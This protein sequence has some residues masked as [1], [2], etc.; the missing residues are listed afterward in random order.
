MCC[1]RCGPRWERRR[2]VVGDLCSLAG[3]AGV[4]KTALVR[5]FC[6]E[7]GRPARVLWGA[8]D[9]LFT[10]R[11]LGPVPRR[12]RRG[13]GARRG[14]R[15]R[16]L[17]PHD[18]A[19]ALLRAGGARGR[20]SS[21][22]RTC[23]GPTRR[24]S[25]SCGCWPAA[26]AARRLLVV[27]TYRDDE[28]ERDASAADRARRARDAQRRRAPRRGAALARRRRRAGRA[29]A[30]STRRS[31]TGR[32]PATRSSS[33]RS[34][35]RATRDPARRSARRCSGAPRGSS[36]RPGTLLEA[37]AVSPQRVEVWLLEALAGERAERARGVPGVGHARRRGRAPS[38]SGT[39]SR[40]WRSRRR[41]S[42][43]GGS[44]CTGWRSP[45]SPTRPRGEPDVVR[46]AHHA[47]A[48]GDVEAVL[49]YAPEAGARAA[50]LRRASRGRRAVRP[51]AALRRRARPEERADLLRRYSDSCYLTDRCDDAIEAP[52]SCSTCHRAAGDRFKEGETLSLSRSCR[53]A[54][55]ASREAEPDGAAGDRAA[56]GVPARGRAG[57]G[58][59]QPGRD[60]HERRGRGRHAGLGE[61][62]IELAERVGD[63]DVLRP[64]ARRRSGRWSSS[65]TARVDRGKVERS[66]EL[67][68]RRR[69]R[70]VHVLRRYSN[71]TWAAW[72]A[73]RLRAGGA[74]P[75]GRAGALPRSPTSTS[76][77][78]SSAA[79]GACLRL[80]QGRVDEAVES[81]AIAAGDPR[82]SP[83]PR[84]LGQRRA[85]PRPAPAA[86]SRSAQALLDEAVAS[87]PLRA[88]SSSGLAAAAAAAA[89]VA[90]LAG[91]PRRAVDE[92]TG[93]ALAL[94][95]EP[96]GLAGSSG[97]SPCWRRRAGLD[98]DVPPPVPEPWSLELAGP[99]GRRRRALERPRVRLRGGAGAGPGRRRGRAAPGPRRAAR[100]RGA[101]GRRGRRAPAAGA[102]RARIRRAARAP[103]TRSNGAQLTA[104][105]LEVAGAAR[106]GPAQRRRSPSGCS[107]RRAPST[108]TS[109]RV[110]RKLDGAHARRSRGERHGASACSKIGSA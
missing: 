59:R 51:R 93:P 44:R 67:G 47:E 11:P 54:R 75:A 80:E 21:C 94:A 7:P 14:D 16:R 68:A 73:P 23:T 5:A 19:A 30:A 52:R 92:A 70:L 13:G 63:A 100:A 35:P 62:A 76:G 37:V 109:R 61:R 49:R 17:R 78:S 65:S 53:C 33:P 40:A 4:G 97:S 18:V 101:R 46:L 57:L 81:A 89:E 71:L 95:L 31:C 104:R 107:S 108:S 106:R 43:A 79:T 41:S 88:A 99:A 2:P 74:L 25:T 26:S 90:W 82:S 24:R 48:A 50:A 56:G 58:V 110:L 98:A 32:R 12:R 87:W 102:G 34:S 85:R 69:A 15:G 36:P 3:E 77:A 105:E 86:A 27:A 55:A 103:S 64:C 66:L 45:R 96:R 9:A 28:L 1:R 20:R 29:G 91:R 42:R 6:D 83:L 8:C 22:S 84:M 38:A 72:R 39:S 10:P 60:L